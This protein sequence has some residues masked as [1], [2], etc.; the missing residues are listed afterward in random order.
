MP[1]PDE[2]RGNRKTVWKCEGLAV[3]A[4]TTGSVGIPEDRGTSRRS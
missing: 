4:V 1:G 2:R 3:Q